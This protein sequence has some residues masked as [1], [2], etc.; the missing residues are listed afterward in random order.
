M[1]TNEALLVKHMHYP[2]LPPAYD[3]TTQWPPGKI[4][5]A[6][7]HYGLHF[8][9]PAP[10]GALRILN[11]KVKGKVGAGPP[12]RGFPRHPDVGASLVQVS[13]CS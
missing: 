2:P 1:P 10:M 13:V 3:H 11:P 9:I 7:L 4:P 6:S 12:R 5:E 8:V